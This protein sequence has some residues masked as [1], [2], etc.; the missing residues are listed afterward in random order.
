MQKFNGIQFQAITRVKIGRSGAS[1]AMKRRTRLGPGQ[2]DLQIWPTVQTQTW[3]GHAEIYAPC[4][5]DT[6]NDFTGSGLA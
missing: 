3:F 6:V 4:N 5:Y 2:G 1:L